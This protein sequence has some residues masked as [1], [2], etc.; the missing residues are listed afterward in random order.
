MSLKKSNYINVAASLRSSKALG[1]GSRA[2]L[3][4]MGCNQRCRGCISPEWQL[5][6]PAHWVDI[7][8]MTHELLIDNP[9][10]RGITIS[11]GEPMLQASATTTMLRHARQYRD[12][13]VLVYSGYMLDQLLVSSMAGVQEFLDE[14]DVLID[15]PYRQDL[16]VKG[17]LFGSSN[18]RIHFL[19]D[20]IK[21]REVT[22][23]EHRLELH[24]TD[25]Q[26]MMVGIPDD[27]QI[28]A[29]DAAMDR[30]HFHHGCTVCACNETNQETI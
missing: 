9:D 12:I 7:E 22:D 25:G 6:E 14:I 5:H 8:T 3:W 19:S 28:A 15:G 24:V 4:L 11:G 21:P 1:P 16:A 17:Q 26:A 30:V 10:V 27:R 18:Q 23:W 20:R 29:F 2:V 13:D